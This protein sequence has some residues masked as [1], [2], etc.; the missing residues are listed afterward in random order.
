MVARARQ[1]RRVAQ[2]DETDLFLSQLEDPHSA[3]SD[4]W[5]REHDEHVTKQLLATVRTDFKEATWTAF[6][7]FALDG[8][9]AADVAKELGLSLNA[10][11]L[12]KSRIMKRL[13]EEARGLMD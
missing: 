4:R 5:N 9:P 8:T 6:Q 7:R 11:I 3:L 10:V 2:K 13:R 1:P 12:A